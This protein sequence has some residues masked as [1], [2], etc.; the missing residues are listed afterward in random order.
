MFKHIPVINRLPFVSGKRDPLV[1][2]L[3]LEGVIGPAARFRSGLNLSDLADAI[4]RAFAP[5]GLTAVALVINSPGG[6]PVQSMLLHKRIRALAEEKGVRVFTVCEDVAASGGYILALA[7]DEII[8]DESSIIGSIGVISAGFGF[9]ELIDKIGVERRV[10]TAGQNK[11]T[12]DPFKPEDP[13]DVTRLKSLQNDVH[14]EFISL[15]KSRRGDRLT[16]DDKELFNGAFWAGGTSQALGLIDTLGDLRGQMR[17]RFGEKVRLKI[18]EQKQPF[19]RR[20]GLAGAGDGARHGAGFAGGGLGFAEGVLQ[21]MEIRGL[22]Q[23]FG[24]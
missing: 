6:S 22:W 2:V 8:A 14:Q 1:T 21:G 24:L 13:E 19:W 23:R 10:Y 17:A 7:G 16:G 18:V 3:R 4:A 5:S 9:T 20:A 11:S 15:V 12:L